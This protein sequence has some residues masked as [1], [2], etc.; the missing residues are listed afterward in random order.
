MFKVYQ[1]FCA[2]WYSLYNLKIVK[3][4]YGGMPLLANLQADITHENII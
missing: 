2:I 3:S 4:T 1:M